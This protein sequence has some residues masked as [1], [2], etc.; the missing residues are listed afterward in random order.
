MYTT[1]IKKLNFPYI[2]LHQRWKKVVE[3]QQIRK[4][5]NEG[6]EFL[7]D[8]NWVIHKTIWLLTLNSLPTF[9]N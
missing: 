6:Q 3:H 8:Q 7:Y 4:T 9:L 5:K 2:F 1:D